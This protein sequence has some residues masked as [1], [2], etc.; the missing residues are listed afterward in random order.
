MISAE[1]N[2]NYFNNYLQHCK[3]WWDNATAIF[4]SMYRVFQKQLYDFDR[5]YIFINK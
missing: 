3:Q 2:M 5:I 1:E 4:G